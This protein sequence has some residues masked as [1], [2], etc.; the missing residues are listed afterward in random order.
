MAAEDI[1]T[2]IVAPPGLYIVQVLLLQLLIVAIRYFAQTNLI[3]LLVRPLCFELALTHFA[4]KS[5]RKFC[6]PLR[7]LVS[8]C[9]IPLKVGYC[10]IAFYGVEVS[11]QFELELQVVQLDQLLQIRLLLL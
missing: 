11:V 7:F 5:V 10:L 4:S 9:A 2:E 8:N 3:A 6:V 1:G